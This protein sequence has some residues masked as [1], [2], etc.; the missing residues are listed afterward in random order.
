MILT[1]ERPTSCG[2][3]ALVDPAET[4]WG[5][6]PVVKRWRR[7]VVGCVYRVAD[8]GWF[9]L[10]PL[11]T[12]IVICGY[13]RAGT[14]LLLAMMEHALPGARRFRGEVSAW[15]AATYVWR[16]HAVM[17]SKKPDDVFQIH[18][19]RNF[20]AG[21]RARLRVILMVRDPRDV[22]TSRHATTG[23]EAY[24]EDIAAWRRCHEFVRAYRN[25]PDVL[26][27]YYRELV[28]DT[29]AVKAR[30]EAFTGVVSER[31]YMDF[32]TSEF[33]DFDTR[34]LNGVRPVDASRMGRWASEEH[35][36]RI[37]QVLREVP[38]FP[39][40][41]VEMGWEADDSW[42]TRWRGGG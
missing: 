8:T 22:L 11:E 13:P 26:L 30:I 42:I 40:I 23:P 17:V 7:R 34:P 9:G 29:P 1:V 36:G 32:Y 19:L 15:R 5:R 35:R 4:I 21:R 20:Y 28:T 6:W 24:F 37:E 41:L 31:P 27:V 33:G 14:T 38:D 3:A 25:D 16:N 2:A 10:T 12:H 18:R 39:E